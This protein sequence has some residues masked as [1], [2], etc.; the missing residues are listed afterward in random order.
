MPNP[1]PV[2]P[3]NSVQVS[4]Y[5]N[6][7]TVF[8]PALSVNGAEV[9]E[10]DGIEFENGS[11]AL[12]SVVGDQV[13]LSVRNS[14]GVEVLISLEYGATKVISAML[15][16][17]AADAFRNRHAAWQAERSAATETNPL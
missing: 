5:Q 14:E 4:R 17:Q 13:V 2:I 10:W 6:S 11:H 15:D 7:A 3:A 12:A 9:T 16:G 8:R 1:D